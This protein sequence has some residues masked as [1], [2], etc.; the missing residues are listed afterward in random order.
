MGKKFNFEFVPLTRDQIKEMSSSELFFHISKFKR[1]IRE[2]ISM[3][4]NTIPFET[5]L[6]YLDHEKQVREKAEKPQYVKQNIF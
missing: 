5:E 2:A 4:M 6:C 3:N 1:F